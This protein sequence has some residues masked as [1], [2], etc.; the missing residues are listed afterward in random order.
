MSTKK[1]LLYYH[2]CGVEDITTNQ[3]RSYLKSQNYTSSLNNSEKNIHDTLKMNSSCAENQGSRMLANACAT[4][5]ELKAAVCGFKGC[6]LKDTAVNTVFS[7]GNSAAKIML[8]GEA[9]G[10]TED[11]QGIPFCGESGQLLDKILATINLSRKTNLY[12]TNAMFW[13]PP[14][15]RKP[16]NEELETCLPFVEKHIALINPSLVIVAGSVALYALFKITSPISH[17]RQKILMYKNCYTDKEIPAIV[18]FHPSYLLRQPMQK[19]L[20]WQDMLFIQYT[21]RLSRNPL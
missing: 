20:A 8:I 6:A 5:D 10:A 12:I 1:L 3:L 7:D 21:L 18:I 15:N 19:K 2:A 16:T 13:R 11:Q 4:L 17:C 9:P 14:G